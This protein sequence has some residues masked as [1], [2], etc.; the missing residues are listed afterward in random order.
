ML[1][2]RTEPALT[3]LPLDAAVRAG[4]HVPGEW[5]LAGAAQVVAPIVVTVTLA[6][7]L[8]TA[9]LPQDADTA[10]VYAV[11]A[12]L[13]T[14]LVVRLSG[15]RIAEQHGGWRAAFGFTLPVLRD[16]PLVLGFLAAQ[17]VA[18]IA[19]I[20]VLKAAN[21]TLAVPYGEP[22]ASGQILSDRG[23]LLLLIGVVL[24]APVMEELAFRG[25]VL[26]GLMRR[27][28]FWPSA[29]ASSVLFAALHLAGVVQV[30]AVP[31][32]L[33]TVMLFALLQCVLVRRTGRLGPA[34]AVHGVL[35]L[36]ITAVVL[37]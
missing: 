16:V 29:L 36:L 30:A 11:T 35:N 24:V 18:R 9:Q 13:V 1:T 5:F 26:R 25:V 7:V 23:L 10:Q 6:S 34:M 21:P 19:L 22:A 15:Q 4:R 8:L 27:M 37:I 33:F 3:P 14:A 28:S 2:R 12:A 17:L 31:T 32:V 20:T